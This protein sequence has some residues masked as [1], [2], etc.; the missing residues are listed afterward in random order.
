LTGW[1]GYTLSKHDRTFPG[2][3]GGKSFPFR[4]DRTHDLSV[5]ANYEINKHINLCGTWVYWTGEAVTL[6]YGDYSVPADFLNGQIINGIAHA[7]SSRNG[8]R[9]PDYHRMD[10]AIL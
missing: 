5:V 4:Y 1:I 6:A 10:I 2:L 9:I 8:F 7:Y 3:N